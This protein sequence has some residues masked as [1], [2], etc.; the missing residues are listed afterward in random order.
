MLLLPTNA[1][2]VLATQMKPTA[3]DKRQDDK[4]YHYSKQNSFV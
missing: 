1:I 4:Y 2:V 3:L